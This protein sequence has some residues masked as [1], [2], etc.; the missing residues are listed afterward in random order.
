MPPQIF[1]RGLSG[2]TVTVND[3]ASSDAVE[4]CCTKLAEKQGFECEDLRLVFEGKQ[5]EMGKQ[6]GDY[7][8]EHGARVL[9]LAWRSCEGLRRGVAVEG[10]GQHRNSRWRWDDRM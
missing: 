4:A 2:S 3:L 7:G 10:S 6:L 1:V 9:A 8:V 5:L